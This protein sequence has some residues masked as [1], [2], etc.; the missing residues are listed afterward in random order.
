MKFS[1]RLLTARNTKQA[2]RSRFRLLGILAA[3]TLL[4]VLPVLSARAQSRAPRPK[5][6]VPT[7]LGPTPYL[8]KADSPF[9]TDLN[10]GHMYLEDFECGAL[11]VPGVTNSAGT[12]IPPGFEGAIDSVDADDGVID[13][14]GLGGHSLFSGSGATGITFTFDQTTLG[15]FPTKAG[16][17]WTDG[18]GTTTFEAFD[19][20]GA[21]LGTI[22]PVSIADGSNSGETAEDR[23]FGVV[24]AGGISAIKISNTAGGIEVD[25]L[26]YG[27]YTVPGANLSLTKL[28][29]PDPVTPGG[30]LTYTLTVSNAG[31]ATACQATVTDPLP[32]GVSFVSASGTG[33]NCSQASGVVSCTT[34]S[35]APG[36]APDITIVVTAPLTPGLITNTATVTTNAFDPATGNNTASAQTLVGEGVPATPTPTNTPTATPTNTPTNTPTATPTAVAATPTRTA[37]QIAGVVVP[38]LSFPMLVLLGLALAGAALLLLKR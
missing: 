8:S 27:L 38:T 4:L 3:G 7:F 21:S 35:L 12:V 15:A 17:V 6:V 33:W 30:T 25:H 34:T 10:A 29:S 14:S 36:T 2:L 37:T 22:G 13:G 26:Q 20:L 18:D 16:I 32:A 5:A 1:S 31:P 28:D 23:F 24:N 9:L 11:T 19:A